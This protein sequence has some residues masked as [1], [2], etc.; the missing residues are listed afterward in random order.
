MCNTVAEGVALMESLDNTD[1]K[2]LADVFHMG[3]EEDNPAEAMRSGKGHIGHVHFVDSNRKA[4]GMGHLD[5]K[6]IADALIEIE[7]PHFVSA[8]CF[9]KPDS[10]TAAKNTIEAYK[11][12]FPR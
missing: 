10:L 8:E 6:S 1:V 2:L 3:I 4:A 5:L 11:R 9:P 7:Y 12:L